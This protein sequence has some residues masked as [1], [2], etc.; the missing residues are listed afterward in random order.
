MIFIHK[1]KHFHFIQYVQIVVTTDF[2]E[3]CWFLADVGDQWFKGVQNIYGY[4]K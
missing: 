1:Y 4:Q 3:K 2:N